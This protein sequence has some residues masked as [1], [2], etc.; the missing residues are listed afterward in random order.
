MNVKELTEQAKEIETTGGEEIMPAYDFQ[1]EN[2]ISGETNGQCQRNVQ[3]IFKY[4]HF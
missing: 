4:V 1:E 2:H 3:H